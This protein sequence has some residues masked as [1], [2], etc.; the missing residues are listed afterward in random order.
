MDKLYKTFTYSGN[1]VQRWD[2]YGLPTSWDSEN[3]TL[4]FQLP[5]GWED[6]MTS[7][8]RKETLD[9]WCI[10]LPTFEVKYNC[11]IAGVSHPLR[12][13]ER[14][15]DCLE[16]SCELFPLI[17]VNGNNTEKVE[18]CL[19]ASLCGK[20]LKLIRGTFDPRGELRQL[21]DDDSAGLLF[22]VGY[23]FAMFVHFADEQKISSV[24]FFGKVE[25][26][27]LDDSI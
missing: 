8:E 2:N 19:T 7:E 21:G 5:E 6:T 12:I 1:L 27:G 14:E 16:L 4:T 26:I 20:T 24:C 9:N 17:E 11:E 22:N 23:G 10:D 13:I 3:Q 18:V 25:E 15:K